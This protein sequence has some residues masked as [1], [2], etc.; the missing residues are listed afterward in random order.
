[1]ASFLGEGYGYFGQG[2][3]GGGIGGGMGGGQ[4]MRF[5]VGFNRGMRDGF[6]QTFGRD[7]G[8]GRSIDGLFFYELKDVD[9]GEKETT[10]TQLFTSVG[11]YDRTYTASSSLHQRTPKVPATTL[12]KFKNA[13]GKPLTTGAAAV[14]SKEDLICQGTINYVSAG[15]SFVIPSNT[16]PD[17][18]VS[19]VDEETGRD[20]AS[21]KVGNLAYDLVA[22]R[23]LLTFTNDRDAE[24]TLTFQAYTQGEFRGSDI[25]CEVLRT[26]TGTVDKQQ[27]NLTYTLTIKPKSSQKTYVTTRAYGQGVRVDP[28]K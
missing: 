12:L 6:L 2:G 16:S 10:S 17:V 5:D 20:K 21:L 27:V 3:I 4:N 22:H 26:P 18:Y 23:T 19:V 9:A 25:P 24:V 1:L 7:Q 15:G 13:S 8:E 14:F 28:S 11:D